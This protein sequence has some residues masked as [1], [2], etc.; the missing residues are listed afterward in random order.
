MR[1]NNN[2]ADGEENNQDQNQ[3]QD[4]GEGAAEL[5][6]ESVDTLDP[7]NLDDTQKAF[8]EEH[9]AELTSEQQEKFGVKAEEKEEDIDL[10]KLDP[11]TRGGKKEIKEEKKIKKG[12]EDTGDED[13]EIDPDDEKMVSK[14]LKKQLGPVTEALEKI[15][16]IQDQNEVNAF[17]RQN[18]DYAKY[19]GAALKYMGHPAYKNIPVKNIMAIVASNGLQKLGAQ[20]EREAARKVAETKGSGQQQRRGAAGKPDYKN[21]SKEE[22]DAA[23]AAVLQGPRN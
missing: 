1:Q 8:L 7:A 22:F 23:K 2:M 18:P 20:K 15:Q 16:G 10:D 3:N 14:V 9:K 11:E 13:D 17:I 6:L 5:T 4:G 19:E 21:M 12:E